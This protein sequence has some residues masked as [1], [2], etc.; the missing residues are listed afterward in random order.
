MPE[1]DEIAGE[2][3]RLVRAAVMGGSQLAERLA[4]ARA[5]SDRRAAGQSQDAARQSEQQLTTHRDVARTLHKQA[6]DPQFWE[7][8]GPTRIGLTFAAAYEWREHDPH[9]A[10][11]LAVMESGLKDHYGI[12]VKA[13]L[14]GTQ[15][16]LDAKQ[17][18][19][20]RQVMGPYMSMPADA[21][22]VSGIERRNRDEALAHALADQSRAHVDDMNATNARS[23]AAVLRDDA[24]A[25]DERGDTG[26][27]SQARQEADNRDLVADAYERYSTAERDHAGHDQGA[28]EAANT[29]ASAP[30]ARYRVG[31]SPDATPLQ[32]EV[33]INTARSFPTSAKDSLTHGPAAR[34]RVVRGARRE[35]GKG[36]DLG[37]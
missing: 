36:Q 4:R 25:Q 29:S 31:D 32:E 30:Y 9:A 26:A 22:T 5:E 19:V 33:R 24:A 37:R 8:A 16:H 20:V 1:S 34:A 13:T 21:M 11:S 35:P 12:D 10:A 28:A 15:E 2:F 7:K 18:E 6:A 17:L 3:D 27:G 23:E 14:A